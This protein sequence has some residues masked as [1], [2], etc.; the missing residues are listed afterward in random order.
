MLDTI[1]NSI[2]E[3]LAK[4]Q[5]ASGGLVLAAGAVAYRHGWTTITRINRWLKKYLV[6]TVRMDQSA[7]GFFYVSRW[8]DDQ[9]RESGKAIPEYE[10][11]TEYTNDSTVMAIRQSTG[12][13]L[14]N[15]GFLVYVRT[16]RIEEKTDTGT[17]IYN[18]LDFV[19]MRW[20]RTKIE[21]LLHE[22]TKKYVKDDYKYIF[23]PNKDRT[24]WYQWCPIPPYKMEYV[25]L[26]K[27]KA[28]RITRDMET[29]L[30]SESRYRKL[31][32]AYKRT[33]LLYGP[34]GSGKTSLVRALAKHF[35]KSVCYVS[36]KQ[37]LDPQVQA[38]ISSQTR[39]S[40]V[41]IEDV[42]RM[43]PLHGNA[44]NKSISKK[45]GDIL[46][47]LD[48]DLQSLLNSMDGIQGGDGQL[49]IMTANLSRQRL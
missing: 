13:W 20:N 45:E 10:V 16:R 21:K 36:G 12:R 42:D 27:G 1:W 39:N 4:N 23:K 31:G 40:I 3:F 29:F 33:Y 41:L 46:S 49:I 43:T 22:I 48:L 32:I 5:F 18:K 6:I 34:P 38:L 7:W 35:S 47:I 19:S 37:L 44:N 28:S 26:D 9:L 25:I 2:S 30:S 24:S 14:L 15:P 8:I 11:V 17:K